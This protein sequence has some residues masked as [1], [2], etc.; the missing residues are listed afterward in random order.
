MLQRIKELIYKVSDNKDIVIDEN[1]VLLTDLGLDSFT[2]IELAD[3]VEDEFDISIPD[4]KIK[5]LV[6][7]SDVIKC[8]ENLK[9]QKKYKN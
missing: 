2:L 1:T 8:I 9:N 3:S 6:T 7:I 4:K 5:E